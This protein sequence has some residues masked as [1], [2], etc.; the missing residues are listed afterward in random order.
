MHKAGRNDPCPCGSGKKFKKCCEAKGAHK[1]I[2][3]TP[4]T[5]KE[6]S[7]KNVKS[8][9]NRTVVSHPLQQPS[10]AKH[11]PEDKDVNPIL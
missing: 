9:F 11:E 10:P 6:S 7:L 8:L 4:I 1:A 5:E 3:A 2:N